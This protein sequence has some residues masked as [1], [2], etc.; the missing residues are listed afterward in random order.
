MGGANEKVIPASRS[1][2]KS[3]KIVAGNVRI[4]E[5]GG[6][7]HLHDDKANLKAEIPVADFWAGWQRARSDFRMATFIDRNLGTIVIVDPILDRSL[8]PVTV[9][10]D[11]KL[12]PVCVTDG[13]RDI[14]DFCARQ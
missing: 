12:S 13:F 2:T 10:V 4:H 7:V 6:N 8:T 1:K 5:S 9:S 14:D 11:I 3:D